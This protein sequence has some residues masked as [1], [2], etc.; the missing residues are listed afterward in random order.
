MNT[1]IVYAVVSSEKDCYLEEAY[2]S[3]YSAR[4]HNPDAHIVLV[5]DDNTEKTLVG[6]R[7][8]ETRFANE[9]VVV[10][11]DKSLNG[12]M[13]SRILKTTLREHVK[14]DMVFIDSDTLVVKPL[15]E[16]DN[17][18]ADL[19]GVY[20]LHSKRYGDCLTYDFG[21]LRLKKL[22]WSVCE[23]DPY[24]NGGFTFSKDNETTHKYYKLWNENLLYC[25]SKNIFVDQPAL[26]HT[27]CMMGYIMQPLDGVWDCQVFSGILYFRDAKVIHY[28]ARKE[29]TE[30][31]KPLFYMM[32]KSVLRGV[33]ET[34]EISE[35]TKEVVKDHMTGIA[36]TIVSIAGEDIA[37]T[38][39]NLY[40]FF[41]HRLGKWP[42]KIVNSF[43]KLLSNIKNKPKHFIIGGE[44]GYK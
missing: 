7:K 15:D 27:N 23:D 41:R 28:M 35:Q 42:F 20:D 43:I 19:A 31:Y 38:K 26:Y 18:D 17:I 37:M 32:D 39:T 25:F 40:A 14:G 8:E 5:V 22:G 16:L 24:F 33:K 10:P 3:M 6:Q 34:G 9:I 11:L 13:R 36:P 29:I 4:Y 44:F 1:K 12:K 30:G 21:S 2:V